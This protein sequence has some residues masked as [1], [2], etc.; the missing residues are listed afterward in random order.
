MSVFHSFTI[1]V[2]LSRKLRSGDSVEIITSEKSKPTANW[3]DFV[4]TSR[5]RSIIRTSLNEEKKRIGRGTIKKIEVKTNYIDER[6][7][8][9]T[10]GLNEG[11][12]FIVTGGS[13]LTEGQEVR[14]SY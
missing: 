3:L 1:K 10:N 7:A 5:A 12:I 2:P 4:A 9:L 13:L 14:F 6:I 8:I 11:D